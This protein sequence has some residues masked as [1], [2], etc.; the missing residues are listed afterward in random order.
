MAK[1]LDVSKMC[2]SVKSWIKELPPPIS[3][4]HNA[5]SLR[6]A[7]GGIKVEG[8]N[9]CFFWLTEKAYCLALQKSNQ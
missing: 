4:V 8:N 3:R 1:L 2:R 6:G 5:V 9:S 7:L